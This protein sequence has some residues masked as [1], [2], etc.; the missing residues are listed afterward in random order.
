MP[1]LSKFL[2]NYE[3]GETT[4]NGWFI[5]GN[6][7]LNSDAEAAATEHSAGVKGYLNGKYKRGWIVA[8]PSF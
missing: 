2:G 7:R 8:R 6:F 4:P 5:V 3:A 1:T